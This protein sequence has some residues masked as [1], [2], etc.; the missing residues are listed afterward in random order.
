VVSSRPTE[1]Y[2]GMRSGGASPAASVMPEITQQTADPAETPEER[3]DPNPSI[4]V[5]EF[6]PESKLGVIPAPTRIPPRPLPLQ[7]SESIRE[8][9]DSYSKQKGWY[10]FD[11]PHELE[12]QDRIA[13]V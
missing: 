10:S 4:R 5:G 8:I 11:E 2:R 6:G 3:Q 9:Y 13:G 7:R 1:P 12:V